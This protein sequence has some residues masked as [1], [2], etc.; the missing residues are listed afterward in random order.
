MSNQVCIDPTIFENARTGGKSKGVRCYD[1]YA[2]IYDNTWTDIPDDDLEIL[3]IIIHETIPPDESLC[4]MLDYI[5]EN[6]T[7]VT[8]GG[9]DYEWDQIKDVMKEWE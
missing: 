4:A 7:G 1:N 8:I 5:Y 3:R 6:Q 9:I 2:S